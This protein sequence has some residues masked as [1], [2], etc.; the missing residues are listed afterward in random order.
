MGGPTSFSCGVHQMAKKRTDGLIDAKKI[1]QALQAME[2][3]VRMMRVAFEGIGTLHGD[4]RMP[5]QV[6]AWK[7]L[8]VKVR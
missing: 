5:Q 2:S 1:R 4:K 8:R 7:P 3:A 6:R